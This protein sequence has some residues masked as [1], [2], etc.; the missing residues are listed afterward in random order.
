MRR[1]LKLK[2]HLPA[3]LLALSVLA[4]AGRE[5]RAM[6][7]PSLNLVDLLRNSTSILKGTVTGVTD[8]VDEAGF[9]YTE[10]TV[11]ISRTLRGTEQGTYTFR[12]FG[13]LN[14]RLSGDGTKKMLPPS[15]F[16]KYADGDEVLLFLSRPATLT[17]LRT[18]MG[19][20][21][22]RFSLGPGRIEN[23]L[24]NEGLFQNLSIDAGL[25]TANDVRM[26]ET[27]I[28]AVNPD[29]FQSFVERAIVGEW[30]ENCR[31]WNT[32]EGKTCPAPGGGPR[33]P[34]GGNGKKT[35][36]ND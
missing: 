3:A 8:G 34:A 7:V 4:L 29:T 18:T 28:G 1:I 24:A 27:E 17:G 23:D 2:E 6:T 19:L 21:A 31:L 35:I 30:V 16:P 10:I 20:G 32:S 33:P 14:P 15:G 12:Q 9:P 22:G 13:L 11:E 25:S 36:I 26:L 5:A